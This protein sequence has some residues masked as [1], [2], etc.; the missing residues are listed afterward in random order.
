MILTFKVGLILAA[1]VVCGAELVACV[2]EAGKIQ[3]EAVG[4]S[5]FVSKIMP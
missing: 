4:D 1:K 5:K 2:F 3:R